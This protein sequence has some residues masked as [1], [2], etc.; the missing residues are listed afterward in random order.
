MPA[1]ASIAAAPASSEGYLDVFSEREA[2]RSLS[3]HRMGG[4]TQPWSSG[5]VGT[6]GISYH[7]S[8]SRLVRRASAAASRYQS[9]PGKASFD[10]YRELGRRGGI[11]CDFLRGLVSATGVACAIRPW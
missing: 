1:C 3:L 10:Y 7:A 9:A 4:H 2:H 8:A 6:N 5:K 11:L